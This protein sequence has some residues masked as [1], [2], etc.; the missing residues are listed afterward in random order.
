MFLKSQRSRKVLDLGEVGLVDGALDRK[1]QLFGEGACLALPFEGHLVEGAD[2][3]EGSRIVGFPSPE[4][5]Q[6]EALD[7]QV[8]CPAGAVGEE[9][10]AVAQLELVQSRPPAAFALRRRFGILVGRHQLAEL[11][12]VDDDLAVGFPGDLDIDAVDD[13]LLDHRLLAKQIDQPERDPDAADLALIFRFDAEPHRPDEGTASP[14]VDVEGGHPFANDAHAIELALDHVARH[15][16]GN[17]VDDQHQY[18]ENN[19]RDDRGLEEP[20]PSLA[21]RRL[22][23]GWR[24]GRY[25]R[26]G[27]VGRGHGSA[28]CCDFLSKGSV[29]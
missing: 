27:R 3:F 21:R 29:G 12:T 28:V 24:G 5:G 8:Y 23:R 10:P 26:F 20:V 11:D 1:G 25:G 18:G 4:A 14:Q 9:H 13:H 16:L 6:A 15:H 17:G 2:E 22:L 7:I 19:R